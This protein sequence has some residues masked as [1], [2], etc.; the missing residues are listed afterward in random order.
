MIPSALVD[1]GD[2]LLMTTDSTFLLDGDLDRDTFDLAIAKAAAQGVADADN[3]ATFIDM[4]AFALA[5]RTTGRPRFGSR[6]PF[7]PR[8]PRRGVPPGVVTCPRT[9]QSFARAAEG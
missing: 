1:L 4:A 9:M 6:P 2:G 7:V 3:G 8:P 5:G